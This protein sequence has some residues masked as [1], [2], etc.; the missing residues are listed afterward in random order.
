MS[1]NFAYF[2]YLVYQ[3]YKRRSDQHCYFN[4]VTIEMITNC[5]NLKIF[6]DKF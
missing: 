6:G 3:V 5:L 4:D 2:F 1:T